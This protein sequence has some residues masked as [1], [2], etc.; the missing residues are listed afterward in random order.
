[1]LITLFRSISVS[2][3][4]TVFQRIFPIFES[5]W[6][7]GIFSRILSVPQNTIMDLNNSMLIF[8]SDN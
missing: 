7:W 8:N 1:M 5:A 3:G 4:L 6:M 2:A